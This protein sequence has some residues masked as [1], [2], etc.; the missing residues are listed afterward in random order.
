[1]VPWDAVGD[2]TIF[3]EM[4]ARGPAPKDLW[5]DRDKV[6]DA[7]RR[8]VD[9]AL[10]ATFSHVARLGNAAPLIIVA[11]DHQA[12]GFVAGSDN[13]DVAVHM[14]GPPEALS[15]VDHWGWTDGL[16]PDA[17]APVRRMDSF[18]NAFLDAF[19]RSEISEIVMQ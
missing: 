7:Y 17:D 6:R 12:A 5:R 8:S 9:Y 18:R 4:A 16:I 3:D 11:G 15:R 14:I 13:K 10:Q 1:M 2:G 19:T